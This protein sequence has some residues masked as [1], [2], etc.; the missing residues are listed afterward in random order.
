[1]NFWHHITALGGLGIT[2]PICVG[3]A[4]WLAAAHCQRRALHWVLLFGA[5]MLVVVASKI[6]FIGWGV[7]V[8]SLDFAGFSGHAARAGAVFPVAAYLLCR[9]LARPWRVAAVAAGVLLAVLVA[10]SRVKLHTHSASEAVFGLLLGLATAWAFIATARAPAGFAPRPWLVGLTLLVLVLQPQGARVS[11]QQLLTGVALHLA[12]SDR[13]YS[14]TD[15]KPVR[16]RYTP[17]CPDA[18]R[19]FDYLCL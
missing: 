11:S 13:P 7:G 14:R 9:P 8:M 12:G 2:A 5:A 4:A 19:R 18:Q 10:I 15:W 3:I 16:Y 1:M 17:P 6:A